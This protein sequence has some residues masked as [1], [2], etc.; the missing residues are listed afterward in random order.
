VAR[1]DQVAPEPARDAGDRREHGRQSRRRPDR[2]NGGAA[3]ARFDARIASIRSFNRFYTR[4]VGALEE[5]LLDSPFSLAEARVLYEVANRE[6]PTAAA[7]AGELQLDPGYLSRIL[8]RLGK[9]GLVERRV[10]ESD[11]RQSILSL[12]P[13]G[14]QTF[15]RLDAGARAEIATLL[16]RLPTRRQQRLLAG[17]RSILEVLG[18]ATRVRETRYLLRPHRPGDMGWVVSRHGALYAAEY[19]WD[20][21]FEARVASVVAEFIQNFD[22]ERE[23]CWIAELDG[24]PVGSVF[25]AKASPGVAQLRLLLVEPR[26][27]GLGIGKRLV[28]ECIGFARRAGYRQVHLWTQSNLVAARRIY[29]AAGFR[30]IKEEPHQSFGADLVAET[31]SLDL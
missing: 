14:R 13:Q 23:R 26:A 31:W 10:A 28:D 15:A 20:E 25:L 7:L 5:H 17:M 9:L 21:R 27:R 12:T 6:R 11:R 30:C 18:A 3:A 2:Q 1:A 29:A 4:Q 24:E 16:E 8:R 19:G 22:A